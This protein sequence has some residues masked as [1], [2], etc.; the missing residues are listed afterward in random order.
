MAD[1]P[2][3]SESGPRR[4]HAMV[5]C[6]H[7]RPQT[8][9]VPYTRLTKPYVLHMVRLCILAYFACIVCMQRRSAWRGSQDANYKPIYTAGAIDAHRLAT[10]HDG[11]HLNATC[12]L[13]AKHVEL[14]SPLLKDGQWLSATTTSVR[15]DYLHDEALLR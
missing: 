11:S 1:P 9:H 14:L 12:N 13:H 15:M 8:D 10:M 4:N 6:R 3:L 5:Q 2:Q 7:R